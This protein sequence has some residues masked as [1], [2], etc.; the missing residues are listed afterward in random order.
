[1][2]VT[3]GEALVDLVPDQVD[4][5]VVYRPV[6]GGSLFNVALGV[7][8]LGGSAAYLWELSSDAL[9]C[10]LVAALAA[11]GVEGAS[12]RRSDRATP[13][14]VVDLSASEPR[15]A[16]A[17]PDGIMLDTVPPP[18]PSS[19]ACLVIGSAVLA[20]DPVAS[21]VEKRAAEAPL[22]AIDYNVRAPSIDNREAYIA[23]L[24]RLSR[25]G[26]IVKA[27]EADLALLGITETDVF[28]EALAREGAALAILTRGAHG[29]VAITT[30][31]HVAMPSL[32]E[33]VVD[34]VGA[35][36]AFM[37]G[38]L[39]WLQARGA[40]STSALAALTE[41]DLRALLSHAQDVAAVTCAARGAVMPFA[42]DLP[43][44][45]TAGATGHCG[46]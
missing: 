14:A 24:G 45:G 29:A 37:A 22:L 38:L 8:R 19:A 3:C 4:G 9:G 34:P 41:S 44:R 40:L 27:S 46:G 36:D 2:I 17:D 13:V 12:V 39:S 35:G 23:R 30:E 21:A 6:I 28:M 1:M 33:R 10:R 7:A 26:G 11:E 42:R 15:Y 16:I 43:I 31:G 5:D 25:R 32:A 20:R 18:L